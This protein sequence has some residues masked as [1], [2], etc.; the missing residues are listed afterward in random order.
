MNEDNLLQLLKNL[1]ISSDNSE[2]FEKKLKSRI[3]EIN[4]ANFDLKYFDIIPKFDRKTEELD[5]FLS[6]C[7]QMLVNS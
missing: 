1:N 2:N 5:R 3:E 7:E 4:M 6:L